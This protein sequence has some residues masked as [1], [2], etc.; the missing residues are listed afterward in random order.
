MYLFKKNEV[1]DFGK[2]VGFN[3]DGEGETESKI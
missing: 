1:N 3:Y 2:D